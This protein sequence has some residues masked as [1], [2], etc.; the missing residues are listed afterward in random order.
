M[1]I[2][3][4]LGSVLEILKEFLRWQTALAQINARK[5]AFD[6]DQQMLAQG[7]DLRAK[8]DSAR[9][10]G[11]LSAVSLYLDDQAN[12][13]LYAARVRSALPDL[14]GSNLGVSI[15]VS[16]GPASSSGLDHS[17]QPVASTKPSPTLSPVGVPPP[18]YSI[19]G[20]ATWFGLNP[21][22]SDD[23]GDV[24]SAGK[25]LKGAFGDE[26]HN[27]TLI[28]LSIPIPIFK[29]TLNDDYAGVKA[30]RYLFDV[31]CPQTGK[32]ASGVWLVDL[33]PNASLNRPMD[34][35]YG[36]ATSLGL[37]DNAICTWAVKDSTT[38]KYLEI[39]GKIG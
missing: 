19:T 37:K 25:D 31:W 33:G 7:R 38:G 20:L 26:T 9:N 3:A 6:I 4:I 10:A 8:I 39:K 11:D 5:I 16:A 36:L 29:A 30:R 12:A 23:K 21:D 15:G 27:K 17:A 18:P 14:P 32:S 1:G 28:G 2:F 13:A 24:D 35:T 34:M 22:G